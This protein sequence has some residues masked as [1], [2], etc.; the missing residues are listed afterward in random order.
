MSISNGS[1]ILKT[2]L[3]AMVSTQ[4]GLIQDDNEQVP[5]VY[6]L[7]L[8]F[9]AVVDAS[10]DAYTRY[11]L[12]CPFDCYVE[13]FA[14]SAAE[15]SG[16]VKGAITGDGTHVND[17]ADTESIT[18][19]GQLVF[20]PT[21]ASLTGA[22]NTV[23]ASRLLFDGTKTKQGLNFATTNRAHRTFLKGS[24]LTVSVAAAAGA[25]TSNICVAIVLREFFSR[26][27]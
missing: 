15:Q 18:E 19:E 7:H 27:T 2:D 25:A 11:E 26:E 5:G 13:T 22:A 6:E 14:L 24:T 4:L 12:V 1:A 16:T 21:K 3:D 8:Q 10:V 17:L 23:K 9:R 20:W